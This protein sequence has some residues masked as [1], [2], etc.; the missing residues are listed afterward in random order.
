MKSKEE[1]MSGTQSE[2]V[3]KQFLLDKST[4]LK[5]LLRKDH[6]PKWHIT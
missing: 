4:G 2:T 1:E 5:H 6:F 3:L